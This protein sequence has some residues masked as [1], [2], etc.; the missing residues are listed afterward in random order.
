MRTLFSLILF[1]LPGVSGLH[2]EVS[3]ANAGVVLYTPF[4]QISVP[5]G[6]SIDY[7]IDVINNTGSVKNVGV[8]VRGIPKD[9]TYSLRSG[10]WTVNQLSVLP[11]EKKTLSLNVGVPFKVKKGTYHFSVSAPGFTSL[12]LTVI[13]SEEGTFKTEFSTR[14]P[15]MEGN[16]KTSFTFN[17]ELANR[18]SEKQVYAFRSSAPRGWNVSFKSSGRQVSSAQVEPNLTENIIIEIDP[19]DAIAAGSYKIPVSATNSSTSANLEL[20]VVVT[21]SYGM[22][23][24]TPTGL[25]STRVTAGNEKRLGLQVKNT[26]SADLTGIT[27]S[28]TAPIN[29]EVTFDPKEI[30]RLEPGGVSEVTAVIKAD[31]K[32]IAGDYVTNLQARVPEV[33]STAAIRVSVKTPL[34][35]G[36]LG[37]AIIG[38][39]ASSVFYLFRKYGRR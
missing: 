9:W 4:T 8:S 14:Q 1:C 26:G 13:V 19:P 25:L 30:E 33:S 7:T 27:L 5:P 35:Y 34:L 36:W 31:D 23:L 11:D 21:G 37:L 17:A 29:W 22:E 32:A 12:S 3:P 10:G 15:N 16:A 20:E 24:T 28:S 18:T 38:G 6:Q 39:A 2:A